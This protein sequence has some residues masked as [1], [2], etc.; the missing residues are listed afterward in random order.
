[1]RQHLELWQSNFHRQ[2]SL[3]IPRWNEIPNIIDT[4]LKAMVGVPDCLARRVT[5]F[6]CYFETGDGEESSSGQ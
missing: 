2:I 3:V 5:R 6:N 1:M 4:S